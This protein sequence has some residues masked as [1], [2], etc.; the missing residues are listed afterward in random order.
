MSLKRLLACVVL[1]LALTTSIATRVP[2]QTTPTEDSRELRLPAMV[3]LAGTI[4]PTRYRLGPGDVLRLALFGPISRQS[5]LVVAPEGTLILPDLGAVRVAGLTL[6]EARQAVST[7][8]RG[9]LRG[10]GVEMQLVVP[11]S[12]RVYLTGEVRLAGPRIATATSRLIDLLPDT[13]LMATSSQRNIEVRSLD[14]S[15][16][17]GD[18]E[19]FRLAGEG[20]GDHALSDG[21]VVHVPVARRFVGA[22]GGVGRPGRYELGPADSIGTLLRL[23]GGPR[24]GALTERALL[25]RWQGSKRDSQWVSLRDPG[26]AG[27]GMALL[28]SDELHLFSEPDYRVSERV[29]ITGRVAVNGD[30]PIR[31]GQ[32]RLSALLAMAGG[33]LPDAD[34]A[35]VLLFRARPASGP[36]PEFER[37][38]RLSRGEMTASEY[39][40][41]RTRLAGLTPDF[42]VDLRTL[43]A[44]SAND[45]RLVAGDHVMVSRSVRAIRVDGQ[46]RRPGVV[47]YE[48][49]RP[50][51]WY[52]KATGGYTTRSAPGQVRITR[53]SSG[54]TLMARETDVP[55]AGDFLWVP[56]RS[57][58]P[59]WQYLRDTLL[60][61]GQIA[62]VIIALR[63]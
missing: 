27:L 4:D 12:F 35:S 29:G 34:S 25:L 28:E 58:V 59:G 61:L 52:I 37:L 60:I 31:T 22:W 24:E 15:V 36:D 40:T 49:G 55:L 42:R 62:T 63:R 2:A 9:A 3:P 54:Q 30:F 38:S 57:D 10:V 13:L 53:A 50:Y 17:I 48:P 39:E 56:E 46:V 21:D 47:E 19:R 11:R 20:Q 26:A 7:R 23:A 51:S 43:R 41:F 33:T 44:N 1:G 5:T 16:W 18:L 45:P 32:T 14:G 8:I 6:D